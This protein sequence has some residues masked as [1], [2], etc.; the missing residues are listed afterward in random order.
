MLQ[1]I[2]TWLNNSH[3]DYYTGVALYAI[4]GTNKELLNV[5]K[6]G[7]NDFR[8]KKLQEELLAMCNEK[9][10]TTAVTTYEKP[11]DPG[12]LLPP[13]E[14]GTNESRIEKTANPELYDSCKQY[15]DEAYKKVMNER[16]ILFNRA[17]AGEAWEDPNL[18][19]KI[20]DR[21]KL[22][23]NIVTGW[24]QV[25]QLYDKANYVKLHGRLPADQDEPEE[26]EYDNLQDHLVKQQLDNARKALSKLRKK[27]PTP[28]RIALMQ[29]HE[30]NIKKLE[31]KW[32]SLKPQ[33]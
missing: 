21:V 4:V 30:E 15:A 7:P 12:K 33:P 22:A 2:R 11:N 13:T 10:K 14:A 17:N 18:T 5:L 6:K 24:Q 32:R 3:R 20:D 23:L 26:P 19:H 27:E 1:Q 31:A 8:V 9:K 16:A 29:K 25:S 28:K